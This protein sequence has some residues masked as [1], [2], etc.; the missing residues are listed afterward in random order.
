MCILWIIFILQRLP[1][2]KKKKKK[3]KF[4]NFETHHDC[5]EGEEKQATLELASS[6][7]KSIFNPQPEKFKVQWIK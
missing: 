5:Q 4:V 3:K 2:K 1:Q 7:S 6:S